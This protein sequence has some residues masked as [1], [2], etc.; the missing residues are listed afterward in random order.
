M[1]AG[2]GGRDPLAKPSVWFLWPQQPL[3]HPA[4]ESAVWAHSRPSGSALSPP[5]PVCSLPSESRS[6]GLTFRVHHG[7]MWVLTSAWSHLPAGA[8]MN[9]GIR[10]MLRKMDSHL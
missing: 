7:Q 9:T 8:E 6:G 3:P 1:G 2:P 5:G 10:R 4:P